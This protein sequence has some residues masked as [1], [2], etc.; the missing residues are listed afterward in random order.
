MPPAAW[1]DELTQVGYLAFGIRCA[2]VPFGCVHRD[3]AD[4]TTWVPYE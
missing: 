3:S 4:R 2:D 1:V